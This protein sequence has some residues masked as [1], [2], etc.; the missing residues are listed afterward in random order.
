MISVIIPL[1]NKE[2]F[3]ERT[4]KS[5]LSQTFKEFEAIFV[6]DGSTDKSP[7]IVEN[8]HD[9]RI[10]LVRKENGGPSSARNLG[11]ERAKYDWILY[12]D[13][14]DCLLPNA[15]ELFVKYINK[16]GSYDCI[17]GNF[18]YE[19]NGKRELYSNYKEGAIRNGFKSFVLCKCMPRTGVAVF[20]KDILKQIPFREDLRRYED[21]EHLFRL[22]KVARF[23][24]IKNICYTG[25]FSVPDSAMLCVTNPQKIILKY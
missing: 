21:L 11:V 17:F 9:N 18:Y 24:R 6:D 14:D 4:I 23:Y 16:V 3:I 13:A 15:L 5:L 1:Y 10:K 22:F 12:L 8:I 19:K 25:C 2:L 7:Q 20:R